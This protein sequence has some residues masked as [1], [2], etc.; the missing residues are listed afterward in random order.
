MRKYVITLF[1]LLTFATSAAAQERIE[2][3]L[4]KISN[5]GQSNYSSIVE[6]NPQTREI[7]KVVK[8][9][10]MTGCVPC[11]EFLSAFRKEEKY[12]TGSESSN[13]NY[14]HHFTLI[15]AS[16]KKYSVYN[17]TCGHASLEVNVIINYDVETIKKQMNK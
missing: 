14:T 5:A 1:A 7:K 10:K 17:L 2:W 8:K 16:P 4:D 13:K 3:L 11:D 6:R 15:F 12:A 9:L